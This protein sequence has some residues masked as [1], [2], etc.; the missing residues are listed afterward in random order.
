MRQTIFGENT[1]YSNNNSKV[2]ETRL[3]AKDVYTKQRTVRSFEKKFGVE[4]QTVEFQLNIEHK[5]RVR[6]LV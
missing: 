4:F 1:R 5:K 2:R 6:E 3:L